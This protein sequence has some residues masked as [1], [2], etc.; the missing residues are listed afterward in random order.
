MTEIVSG[1]LKLTF[2]F[3]VNK[4]RSKISERLNDGDV[5]D[6][7]CR[8]LIVRELDDIKR[9]LDGLAR[10][11][12]LSSLCF[13]EEGINGLY[14]SLQQ[15]KAFENGSE[16]TEQATS[17][18]ATSSKETGLVSQI[19]EVM[20][21]INAFNSLKMHSK[22][23]YLSA[24][25]SFK[26]A[27]EKATEAFCNEALSIEDRIQATQVRMMARIL[28]KSEDP[29]AGVSDCLQ[30]LK[31]LHDV[32]AIQEIFS[33]VIDGG[34]K[35]PFNKTKRLNNASSVYQMNLLLFEFAK[36]FSNLQTV[37]FDWPK[38]LLGK[39]THHPLVGNDP[40]IEKYKESGVEITSPYLRYTFSESIDRS[41]CFVNSKRE[42]VAKIPRDD[43]VKILKPSGESRTI[44]DPS[45]QED[46]PSCKVAAMDIDAEDNL[47]VITA[48]RESDDQPWS[49]KLMIFD[50]NGEKKLESLLPFENTVINKYRQFKLMAEYNGQMFR[51]LR[52]DIFG[53]VVPIAVNNDKMIAVFDREKQILHVGTSCKTNSFEVHNSFHLKE[54]SDRVNMIRFLDNNGTKIIAAGYLK[55]CFYIYTENGEL[56]RKVMIPKKYGYIYSVA[57][58]YITK[59]ILVITNGG[60]YLCSFSETGELKD[61]V[62]LEFLSF[63]KII[64][65]LHGAVALVWEQ[66]VTFLQL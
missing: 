48:F 5:T 21:L 3:L 53:Y 36:R 43:S 42:V 40:L 65:N 4:A 30:Y 47:Y 55:D 33:V 59:R 14:Q 17:A 10:K 6:E 19:N 63:V 39:K 12:L 38:I 24:I 49:Y 15:F 56:E 20:S 41:R 16:S 58:N 32:K 34:I 64:S 7:E 35:S 26:L 51:G 11:D 61:D 50:E 45:K 9:K 46:L 28:E 29:D 25:E 31:Q 2:G 37:I 52:V 1:V 60:R 8:R 54:L 22:E 23:R 62:E 66:R 27:R 57:I 44:F 18:G 13:L